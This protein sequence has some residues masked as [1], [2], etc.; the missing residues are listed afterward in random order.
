MS[1]LDMVQLA[2][3]ITGLLAVAAPYLKSIPTGAAEHLGAKG[4]EQAGRLLAR[5]RERLAAST[6]ERAPQTLTLFLDDPDT[7]QEALARLLA[8]LLQ[9]H[10][11]WAS[12]A[13]EML[14][15]PA[16]QQILARN[17][18]VVRDVRMRMQGRS[19]HQVIDADDSHISG[20]EM[21]M[22]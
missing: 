15:Q 12:E 8:G 22:E 7:F 17:H 2:A 5:L 21:D 19:G 4:V 9:Q 13:Q 1:E 16:L 11:E 10:P 6:E 14:G 18:A 20:I 3:Q